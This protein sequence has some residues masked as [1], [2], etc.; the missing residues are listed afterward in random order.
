MRATTY[1]AMDGV[2]PSNK[3]QGYIL[4]RILRRMIRAGRILGVE[5][6][7]SVRLVGTIC[8]MFEWLYPDLPSK[9]KAIEQTFAGEEEKFAKT[10]QNG[11]K[12]FAKEFKTAADV[13][14]LN[15][16]EL[17]QK[18]FT[19]LASVGYPAEIFLEDIK[20]LG[21]KV[22]DLDFNT[23]L[24]Q[25]YEDH[26]AASRKGAE[27]KFKGGLADQSAQTVAYHTSTHLLQALLKKYVGEHVT[28]LGSNITGERLRFDFP[29]ETKLS[30][31]VLKQ[32]EN[33]F[34]TIIARNLPVV[35]VEMSKAEAEKTGALH[36]FGEKYGDVVSI[37][38]IGK[39][40]D[41]AVSK[42]FCGGPHVT[43]TSE[44]KP[45]T[46]YKQETIG[47][48]IQRLYCKS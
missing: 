7:I 18:A 27:Q 35:R 46:L 14:R 20:D 48:G 37:Y 40:V 22:N 17:A 39:S 4:R 15:T 42:E 26:Q 12:L 30:P 41:E 8:H 31:E 10:L 33:E 24:K 44:L 13:E 32:I 38:Y 47:K 3:D 11:A 5:K 2:V 43:N 6:D 36:A 29:N 16:V 21:A 19:S 9:Q 25:I 28:Q 34:A 45:I 1:F 23:N